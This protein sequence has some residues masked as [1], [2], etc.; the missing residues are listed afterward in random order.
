MSRAC[1]AL[2]QSRPP[3]LRERWGPITASAMAIGLLIATGS[4]G[5]AYT[6]PA[7][8]KTS[9]GVDSARTSNQC[10]ESDIPCLLQAPVG[11]GELTDSSA[12]AGQVEPWSDPPDISSP[13]ADAG[14]T[15][16]GR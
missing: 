10:S 4:S 3:R 15:E 14:G 6:A 2:G 5:E 13:D 8:G 16:R 7:T 12:T 9:V 1:G 11:A